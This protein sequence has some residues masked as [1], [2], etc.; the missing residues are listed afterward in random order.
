MSMRLLK[1]FIYFKF[2]YNIYLVELLVL[3]FFI[4]LINKRNIY[5]NLIFERE[6]KNLNKKLWKVIRF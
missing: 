5:N 1:I 6:K 2:R 4:N 3:R